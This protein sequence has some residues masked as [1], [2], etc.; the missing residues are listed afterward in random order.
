MILIY[1]QVSFYD[2][3][4]LL[5]SCYIVNCTCLITILWIMQMNI[6]QLSMNVKYI[7]SFVDDCSICCRDQSFRRLWLAF[8]FY[9]QSSILYNFSTLLLSTYCL[10]IW[11]SILHFVILSWRR[12]FLWT[13]SHWSTLL[14]STAFNSFLVLFNYTICVIVV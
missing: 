9:V 14:F 3:R 6:F 7:A 2:I 11:N 1:T 13:V 10:F 12:V 8:C 5:N 4:N